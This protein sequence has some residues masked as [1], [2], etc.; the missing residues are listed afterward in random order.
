[1]N[2][3]SKVK[4]AALAFR[5]AVTDGR[6]AEADARLSG[7]VQLLR[8]SISPEAACEARELVAWARRLVL[9][10]KAALAEELR[11]VPA[12]PRGYLEAAAV[13]NTFDLAG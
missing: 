13:P 12:V 1:M 10:R 7:Y 8:D 11:R 9:A 2:G 5:E 4:Q 6:Y 3:P